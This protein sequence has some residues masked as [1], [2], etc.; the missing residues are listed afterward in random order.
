LKASLKFLLFIIIG[1]E[2]TF[3]RSILFNII[4]T[5]VALIYLI[6]NRASL[7]KITY[8]FVIGIIPA[9]STLAMYSTLAIK[10]DTYMPV[11]MATRVFSYIFLGAASIAGS[12]ITDLFRSFEQNFRLSPTITYGVIGA[13]NFIPKITQ[14]IK[15]IKANSKMR[16]QYMSVFSPKLYLKAIY[17]AMNWS[18]NLGDAMYSH[19][20]QEGAKRTNFNYQSFTVKEILIFFSIILLSIVAMLIK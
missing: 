16:G 14:Q 20:F 18:E 12:S 8:L 7:K 9:L 2:L 4:T 17:N 10:T 5:T 1:I 11:I 3:V 15:L 13:F 19:G 6:Y